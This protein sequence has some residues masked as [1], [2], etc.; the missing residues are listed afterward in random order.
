M[1]DIA[2]PVEVQIPS[3]TFLLCEN[4][5]SRLHNKYERNKILG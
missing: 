4:R 5:L 1:S 3:P 2:S